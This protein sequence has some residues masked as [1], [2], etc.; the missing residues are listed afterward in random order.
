MKQNYYSIYGKTGFFVLYNLSY[1]KNKN[2]GSVSKKSSFKLEDW[3]YEEIFFKR[4]TCLKKW[5]F[6]VN[7]FS[8]VAFSLLFYKIFGKWLPAN[9]GHAGRE[10]TYFNLLL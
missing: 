9:K 6:V 1:K 7:F 8:S 2:L 3:L 5:N 10:K 4:H